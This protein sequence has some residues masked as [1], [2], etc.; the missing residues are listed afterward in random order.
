MAGIPTWL[1][2]K[3]IVLTKTP[4]GGFAISENKDEPVENCVVFETAGA[5]TY[6]L[7]GNWFPNP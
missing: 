6:Y 5:L 1:S 2:N 7:D 3:E 4:N